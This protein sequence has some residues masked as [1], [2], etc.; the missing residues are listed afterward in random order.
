MKSTSKVTQAG[1][2]AGGLAALALGVAAFKDSADVPRPPRSPDPLPAAAPEAPT[3]SLAETQGPV[4]KAAPAEVTEA[5]AALLSNGTP[6]PAIAKL[7]ETL[8]TQSLSSGAELQTRFVLGLAL[9]EAGFWE[10]A[11]TQLGLIFKKNDTDPTRVKTATL[12]LLELNEMLGPR[13]PF[14]MTRIPAGEPE[15]A[16][17]R[18]L[19]PSLDEI[20]PS[21]ALAPYLRRWIERMRGETVL[22]DTIEARR[23]ELTGIPFLDGV[24]RLGAQSSPGSLF[25]IARI[26]A[27]GLRTRAR[28]QINDP[29]MYRALVEQQLKVYADLESLLSRGGAGAA[30]TDTTLRHRAELS[31]YAAQQTTD[32]TNKTW[33]LRLARENLRATARRGA[34]NGSPHRE[35]H[36]IEAW[37]ELARFDTRTGEHAQAATA[38]RNALELTER[39]FG[40]T[41]VE[42]AV[43]LAD[44]ITVLSAPR[45]PFLTREIQRHRQALSDIVG[46]AAH[47]ARELFLKGAT[48]EATAIH[49]TIEPLQP[50]VT[51]GHPAVAAIESCFRPNDPQSPHQR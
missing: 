5:G 28:S 7:K 43:S 30:A 8:T 31:E 40:A 18:K 36:H 17:W 37:A 12:A 51:P 27:E 26:A 2:A 6:L 4:R 20:A 38:A 21:G 23:G 47:R 32:T 9:R 1:L 13:V 33:L 19:R 41:S 34:A 24:K 15:F 14:G 46:G 29:E 48:A 11:Q 35:V 45:D 22:R 25:I 42:Y 44:V 39:F 3:P 16:E 49:R 50:F 10:E